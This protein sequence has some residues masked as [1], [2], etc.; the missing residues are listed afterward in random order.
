MSTNIWTD[1][2]TDISTEEYSEIRDT[3]LISQNSFFTPLTMAEDLAAYVFLFTVGLILNSIILRCYWKEK[4][5]T[6]TYFKAFAVVDAFTL[7]IMIS[8]GLSSGLQ[9]GGTVF[10]ATRLVLYWVAVL[11]N[12]GPLFLALDR[13]LV[14]AFPYN[15]REHEGKMRLAKGGVLIFT[16]ALNVMT[17]ISYL[18]NPEWSSTKFLRA[19]AVLAMLLQ[20]VAIVVLYTMIVVKV[21]TSDRNMK[22]NRH[23]GNK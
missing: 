18:M 10:I 21:V 17:S 5:A 7:I 20:I 6:S 2:M 13:C 11:Y 3:E 8:Y 22:S 14:V 19:V 23:F 9:P 16:F 4:S 1:E 12:F 15:F